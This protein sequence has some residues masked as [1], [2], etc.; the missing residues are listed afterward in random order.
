MGFVGLAVST[1]YENVSRGEKTENGAQVKVTGK[2]PVGRPVRGYSLTDTGR[3]VCDD[4]IK[5][6]LCGL[7]VGDG[8]PYGYRKL[9]VCLRE[10]YGLKINHKKV[11][12]LC[13][14]LRILR[15]QRIVK[16]NYPRRIAKKDTV[17]GPN[18]LWEMDVKYGYITG[19]DSFF[20]QLSLLDVFDRCVIDYHLGTSCTAS[21]AARVLKNGL[22]KRGVRDGLVLPKLRTDNGPQ[23]IA[24]QFEEVCRALGITHERIPVK[25]PNMIAHIEAF[26]SILEDECYTRHE[27]GSF[28]EAYAIVAEY[29]RYYN[30]RRRHGAIGF[31]SPEAFHEAF[32]RNTVP[33]RVCVA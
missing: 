3:K 27:F 29:I 32:I 17:S 10:D 5:E 8:F 18:Q 9:A 33:A 14:E 22:R 15:P 30:H 21:D 19:T 20:F 16:R 12:R 11:Y 2:R 1:Y 31:M 25:T 24:R 7:I 26:H 4:Q 6:W 28:G 23:F 13:K